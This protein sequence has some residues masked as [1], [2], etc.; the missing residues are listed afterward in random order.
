MEYKNRLRT[1]P[2]RNDLKLVA[3][4]K[5]EIF[6]LK[7]K[8]SKMHQSKPWLENDL[9]LALR[10]LKNNKSRDFE[11]YANEIFKN[12]II[13]SDL[14]KSLLIMFN[15]LKKEKLTPEFMNYANVTTVP[16][17]GSRLEHKNERGIFRV[18]IIRSILMLLIYNSKY[19]N[20]DENM[21]DCQ[22]GATKGKEC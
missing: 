11:G 10:D 15:G 13:G 7:M 1:R 19:Y 12:G 17:S 9:E 21:S 16:K 3:K 18:K 5:E 2:M 22:I 20:I 4:R 8:L 6:D 14:K